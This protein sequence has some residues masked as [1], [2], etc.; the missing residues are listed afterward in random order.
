YTDFTFFGVLLYA[1]VPTL[2]LGLFG[3]AD[4]RWALLVTAV[5]LVLQYQG[6]LNIRSGFAVREIWIV[7]GFAAW[8]WA[9]VRAFASVRARGDWL[10]YAVMGAS[11]LPLAAAKLVPV[12]SPGSQFG[13]LGIS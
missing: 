2:I 8:Q 9:D 4:W 10:F 12:L 5:M 11:L 7:I 13:F 6:L 1:V 3:R